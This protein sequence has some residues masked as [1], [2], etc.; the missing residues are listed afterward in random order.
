[1]RV[2]VGK[3]QKLFDATYPRLEFPTYPGEVHSDESAT[4]EQKTR[5][6]KAAEDAIAHPLQ[7]FHDY[8]VRDGFIGDGDSPSI[9]DIRFAATLEFLALHDTPLPKWAQDYVHRVET[10]LG[11]AY[12]EPAAD[13]RGYVGSKKKSA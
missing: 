5:A 1:M 7:V 2:G 11:K 10:K 4:A 9:A 8:F 6:R 12:S 3:V 13:V